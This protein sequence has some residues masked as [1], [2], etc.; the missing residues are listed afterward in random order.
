MRWVRPEVSLEGLCCWLPKG[1]RHDGV[2]YLWL[3]EHE[4]RS[5]ATP[6]INTIVFSVPALLTLLGACRDRRSLLEAA[7]PN[8]DEKA[9]Q[10]T[11]IACRGALDSMGYRA[12][13][14]SRARRSSG[15]IDT[16]VRLIMTATA[17][18]IR[19]APWTAP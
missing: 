19:N 14:R 15:S 2:S 18:W 5:I 9:A 6:K 11:M 13:A 17:T 7:T 1:D 16:S 12:F 3:L 10:T 4:P 8:H